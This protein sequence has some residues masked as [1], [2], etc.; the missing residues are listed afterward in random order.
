M[1]FCWWTGTQ[2][3]AMPSTCTAPGSLIQGLSTFIWTINHHCGHLTS[4]PII[5]KSN[6]SIECVLTKYYTLQDSI[7]ALSRKLKSA[8][9]A[10]FCFHFSFTHQC[11]ASGQISL[12]F[13]CHHRAV[14]QSDFLLQPSSPA[15]AKILQ[16]QLVHTKCILNRQSHWP[17]VTQ[18]QQPKSSHSLANPYHV[19]TQDQTRLH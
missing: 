3:V 13:V 11:Q 7:C 14:E 6:T 1:A 12:I 18:I 19:L 10:I 8:Q 17:W 15:L 16:S 9:F 5:C 2:Q 4:N